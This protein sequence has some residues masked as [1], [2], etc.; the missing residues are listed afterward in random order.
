MSGFWDTIG[1]WWKRNGCYLIIFLVIALFIFLL[2]RNKRDGEYIG[3]TNP[4]ILLRIFK[5]KKRIAKKHE[6]ECRRIFEKIYQV[7]FP[8][9]RPDFLKYPKT[10]R[11]LELDGYNPTLRLAFE[12]NGQQHAKYVKHF[13]R[14]GVK[15]FDDQ[16]DRDRYKMNICEQLG[17]KVIVIP[18]TVK[19]KNLESYIT[20]ELR[21]RNLLP[22]YTDLN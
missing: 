18:H 6:T 1:D 17:V 4:S 8:S 22:I 13:H 12:Y 14:R 21:N 15:D 7:R 9:I 3:I 16:Q 10:G 11:N 5:K 19:Y 20:K 2:I